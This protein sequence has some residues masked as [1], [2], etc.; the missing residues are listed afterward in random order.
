MEEAKTIF[1]TL[2]GFMLKRLQM[3]L[4]SWQT[5]TLAGVLSVEC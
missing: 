5:R 1:E 4:V 3:A 2:V